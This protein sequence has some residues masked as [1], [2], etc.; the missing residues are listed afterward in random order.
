MDSPVI[1]N[2]TISNCTEELLSQVHD[3]ER[4]IIICDDNRDSSDQMCTVTR[5]RLKAGIFISEDPGVFKSAS[6]P[7]PGVVINKKEGKQ[8]TDYV[9]NSI[10]PTATITF[11][12]TYL[13]AKP[14]PVVPVSSARGPSRSYLG[15][16]KPDILAPWVLILA[17]YPP[18]VF[19]TSIGANIQLSSDY[20]L[21]S[22]T[23]MAAPHVAGI[24]AML[25][26][27]HPEWS[28]S[29]I[30]SAMMTTAD[31]LDNTRKHI[32]D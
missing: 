18:N 20:I 8:V 28:L 25:K 26:T 15:I 17:A 2:N 6:F 14:A 7:N 16:A 27:A 13:D 11:Q 1:Y 30:R 10:A 32:Q 24:A 9:K 22:G 12:E 5:A 3:P 21:E 29:A 19:A 23:S 4:T 31:P